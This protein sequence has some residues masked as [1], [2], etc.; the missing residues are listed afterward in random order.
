MIGRDAI[1]P[2]KNMRKM[3][4]IHVNDKYI[5]KNHI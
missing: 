2:K 4:A 3:V 1:F 5:E